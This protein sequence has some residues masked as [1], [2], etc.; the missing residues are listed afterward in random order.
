V[1]IFT[2][3]LRN[4][5]KS[6]NRKVMVKDQKKYKK[7]SNNGKGYHHDFSSCRGYGI[8]LATCDAARERETS[9]EL[10]NIVNDA[11]ER[12]YPESLVDKNVVDSEELASRDVP[13][14]SSS[15]AA[16]LKQEI[17]EAKERK[18]SKHLT[19]FSIQTGVKGITLV[20]LLK[21]EY[22]PVKLVTNIF[23]HIEKEKQ[24]YTRYAVRLIPLQYVFFPK[25]EEFIENIN[26]ILGH[27]DPSTSSS[28]SSVES[29]VLPTSPAGDEEVT[30]VGEKRPPEGIDSEERDTKSAKVEEPPSS[31][32]HRSQIIMPDF[33]VL[34]TERFKYV[35]LFKS[36]NHNVLTRTFVLNHVTRILQSRGIPDYKQPTVSPFLLVYTK[37]TLH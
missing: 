3:K 21:R 29:R 33:P 23:A 15:L 8:I 34:P 24:S 1:S 20:K 31:K 18:S 17:S 12:V 25:E 13:S 35:V 26:L 7:H 28:S 11:I 2:G 22:C 4:P 37:H 27:S 19:V 14:S 32:E 36:R 9:K 10:V 30:N 5:E 16:L 6:K